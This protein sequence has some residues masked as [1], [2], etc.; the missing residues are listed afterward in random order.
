MNKLFKKIKKDIDDHVGTIP[1]MSDEG[2]IPIK[3]LSALLLRFQAICN[4]KT[5]KEAIKIQ[6]DY[7]RY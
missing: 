4:G 6:S 7:M 2:D 1:I 5:I 3:N